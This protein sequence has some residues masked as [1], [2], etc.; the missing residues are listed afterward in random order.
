MA[1]PQLFPAAM[2]SVAIDTTLG[3]VEDS[4]RQARDLMRRKH[5][6]EA[7]A[8]AERLI[9]NVPENRDVLYL[10]AKTQRFLNETSAAM[11][12]LD[13][14]ER[15]HP[16]YSR[17][18]EERGHCRVVQRDAPG[19]IDAFLHAVNINPALPTSWIMLERLYRMS[20]DFANAATAAAHVAKLRLLAPDVVRA[21][22]LFSDGDLVPAEN[23]IRPYLLKFGNDVEAMRLLARIGIA[24]D[25]LDDAERLLAAVM[26][27]AP[28][29]TA[30]RHDYARVLLER[31]KHLQ[32]REQVDVLLAAEPRHPNYR[33]LRAAACVGLGEHEFAV[34]LY[35]DLISE[36]PHDAELHLSL[37]HSL[38]TLGHRQEAIDEYHAAIHAR[39]DFGDAYWSLANL[40][41]YHFS[42]DEIRDM[43]IAESAASTTLVDRYHL[44][45]ALGKAFENRDEFAESW[46]HYEIGNKLKR[47]E[48]RYRPDIIETNTSQQIKT[49]TKALFTTHAAAGV[50][51]QDPIF[52]V[53]LPR[54][55]ST[56]LEQILA[57]HSQV[58]GTQELPNIPRIV[59]EL[60]GERPN[61]NDPRYPKVLTEIS[62]DA[63]TALGARYLEETRIY[64]G[65]KPFFVDKMPNN[66]RHIG[67]IRL[68]LPNAKIIDA[69]REP[70]ACCFSNLKQLFAV[71]QEFSYSV[72]DIAR[73]YRTYLDLMEHWDDVLPG[74]VLRVHYED[75]VADTGKSVRRLLD[76][77]GLAFEQSCLDFFKSR[78]SVRTASSEQVRQP[79]FDAGLD[80]WKSYGEWLA[81]L[82]AELGDAVSRYRESK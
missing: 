72:N 13:T 63:F 58:D 73:Y 23:I 35:R 25:V 38:K 61:L 29:Y 66:F 41:T 65:N 18:H 80:Q 3:P 31:H 55:G 32:T 15:H 51:N 78:R 56:L 43:Q 52:I 70:I 81:P 79:I 62:D 42:E 5:Y 17:L 9:A 11:Q 47:S 64:R 21:T 27:M 28:D 77:C 10:L 46:R 53:G 2:A 30:A 74:H 7:M 69:R 4:V 48:S 14:L 45:F 82:Q 68:M 67:L 40:K 33:A 24:C 22:S 75:V 34:D 71:G 6:R 59:L 76:F 39:R 60:Q 44:N 19:A 37:A 8:L 1:R 12:T 26:E 57:S 49:C 20:G 50:R 36:F 54:A 16:R